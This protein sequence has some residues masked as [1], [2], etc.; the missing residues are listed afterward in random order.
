MEDTFHKAVLK[1][2]KFDCAYLDNGAQYTTEH[3]GK[4]CAKLGIRIVHAKP[5]ACQSKGKIEKFHQKVDQFMAEIRAS[6]VHCVEE[7]N[8]RWKIFLEREYQKEAHAG[9]KEYYESYG[10][11]VP[12]CGIA[13]EQEW[14]RDARGLVF[15]DVSVVAEAFLRHET[16]RIDEAGCFSL[17]GSRYEASAALANMEAFRKHQGSWMHW[18]RNIRKTT[19]RWRVPFPSGSTGRRRGGMYESFFEMEHTPF[20]RD[21]P[22]ERLYTSPQ[23]ED[24]L[25]RLVYV[26]DHQM[27]AVVT[28][29]PGCGKSTM[30]RML[31]GRLGK[32]KYLLLY[33]SDSKLTPRWLYAGLLGQLGLEPHYFSG[34]SK[35]LLQKEI[36]TVS[37]EQ[38]K[39]VV[40]ALDEARLLGKDMLEELRF[41][42]NYRFD[43]TSPMSLALVGQTELWERKL[44][45]Q[46]Y[47][48]IRQRIDMNIVLGR[49]D[50]AETGKYVASHMAYAG[51]GKEIFTSGAE[52]EVY[53]ISAGIPRMINRVC[54][55]ALMYARQQQKRL[56][57]ERM[58]RFVADHEMLGGVG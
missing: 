20:T 56:V 12:A 54:E 44:K 24:A 9:I 32:E 48:A 42:L 19:G 40:C 4:A 2:G 10:A 31:D 52:D 43:S 25:G 33:L 57:D 6:H 49:L 22:V 46:A 16:R 15:M 13:P 38:K 21:I 47:E 17:G 41:L 53:K 35:R 18:K 36:Q 3:L 51:A 23:I 50:R 29:N 5:G 34:D 7:L 58:V 37:A 30:V 14:M 11:S 26:V 45:L 28:A 55:K 27:F 1:S 39:K 8:R